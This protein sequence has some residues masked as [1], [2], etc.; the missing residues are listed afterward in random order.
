VVP[1]DASNVEIFVDD[2]GINDLNWP[3]TQGENN[4]IIV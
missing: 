3:D 2:P 1:P 4:E